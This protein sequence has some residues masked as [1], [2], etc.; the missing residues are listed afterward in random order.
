MEMLAQTTVVASA[1][2]GC[3]ARRGRGHVD[4]ALE[5]AE[6]SKAAVEEA[7]EVENTATI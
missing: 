4:K 6:N 7:V 5:A 2:C 1:G 3:H